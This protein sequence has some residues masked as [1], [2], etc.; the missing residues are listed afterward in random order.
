[1]KKTLLLTVLATAFCA[2]V[3]AASNNQNGQPPR[4]PSFS[5][6]D[7]NGDG[8]ISKDEAKGPLAHDFDQAD[9]NGDGELTQTEL[10]T[11]MQSH[12]PPQGGQGPAN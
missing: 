12:Q 9:T 6:I 11:F 8:V 7:S 4:P 3:F 2:P 10:D 5:D 1:M